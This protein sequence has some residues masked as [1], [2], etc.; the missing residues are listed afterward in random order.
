MVQDP[1][2]FL[3]Q[4]QSKSVE[5]SWKQKASL[6][7]RSYL[8][9]KWP[10]L[11][12]ISGLTAASVLGFSPKST[13]EPIERVTILVSTNPVPK[14]TPMSEIIFREVSIPLREFSAKERLQ[15]L[16]SDDFEKHAHKLVSGRD[17]SPGRALKTTDF[18]FASVNTKLS[19]PK[20]PR[21]LTPRGE[22]P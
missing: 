1:L 18:K 17:L 11:I 13:S 14:G 8:S 21:V 2:E 20:R 12:L 7:F 16:Q 19:D 10:S 4:L 3:E 5:P 22:Q 6:H 9:K 15:H